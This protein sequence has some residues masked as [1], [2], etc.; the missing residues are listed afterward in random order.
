MFCNIGFAKDLFET[1]DKKDNISL[2]G[3]ILGDKIDN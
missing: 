1:F 2:F 3:I